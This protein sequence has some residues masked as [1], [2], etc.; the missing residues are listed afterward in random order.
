MNHIL[1]WPCAKDAEQT[2]IMVLNL[3]NFEI[4]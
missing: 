1:G 2:D 3:S 4:K